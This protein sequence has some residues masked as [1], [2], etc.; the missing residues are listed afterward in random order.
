MRRLGL[1]LTATLLGL[2]IAEAG[3]RLTGVASTRRGA[4]WYA[5]GSHPRFLFEPDPVAGYRLRPGFAGVDLA[6]SGEF[7]VPVAIDA[8]GF[9]TERAAGAQG[10]GVLAVGDSLTFG[11]GVPADQAYPARL[12]ALLGVPVANAGV[13]GYSSRQAAQRAAALLPRLRPRLVLLTL[14]APWDLQRCAD[15]FTYKEGYI[16]SSRHAGRLHLVGE[17]LL[18]EQVRHPR[19][20][21]LTVRLMRRSHLLRLALP[22]LRE[23]LIGGRG[24]ARAPAESESWR[25]CRAALLELRAGAAASGADLL[26]ALAESPDAASRSAT[27]AVAAELRAA[28]L[29]HLLLDEAL[30]GADPALRYP[31]DRHWNS[32]GHQRVAAALAPELGRLLSGSS[33]PLVGG[34]TALPVPAAPR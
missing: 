3:L 7:E 13:P 25:S 17:D 20:G 10:G 21:P 33:S 27:A 18:L 11:E 19:L 4:A 9:R 12:Q 24:G 5:G 30:G 34:G 31:R 16:V 23:V 29:A 6:R 1:A 22:A 8:L 15:P 32:L 2:L 26:V 14:A 28:G